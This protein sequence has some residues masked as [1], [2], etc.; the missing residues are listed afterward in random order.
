VKRTGL[1]CQ[2]GV[3]VIELMV[4]M[5]IGLVIMGALVASYAGTTRTNRVA[6]AQGEMNED[7]QYA[8]KV[9]MRQV[10]QAGY[11]PRQSTTNLRNTLT[12]ALTVI[13]CD[14]GFV[15][16]TAD[17]SALQCKPATALEGGSIAITYEA[18]IFNTVPTSGGIPTHC[19]GRSAKRQPP[20]PDPVTHY[21][22]E[23]RLFVDDGK[24]RCT[25][26]SAT[27]QTDNLAENVESVKFDYGVSKQGAGP[28]LAGYLTATEIGKPNDPSVT[29]VHPDLALLTLEQRWALV[30]TVRV[31]LVMRSKKPVFGEA[32]KSR[33]C[34]GEL[35][36][37]DRHL[38]RAYF[39]TAAIRNRLAP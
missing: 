33:N 7:A 28:R 11:N 5:I 35:A 16:T 18:D 4:S 9:I 27:D 13:G 32:V 20:L 31:C 19:L 24:L 1:N 30:K 6:I 14:A 15:S 17:P 8:L 22:A 2:A 39:A 36:E 37:P 3:S 34:D 29:G 25:G 23:N 10:Q 21:V 26:L 38:R 12:T